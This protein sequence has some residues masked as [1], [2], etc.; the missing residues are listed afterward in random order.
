LFLYYWKRVRKTLKASQKLNVM[1][2][3]STVNESVTIELPLSPKF[4]KDKEKI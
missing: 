3:F 4:K 1:A 2:N